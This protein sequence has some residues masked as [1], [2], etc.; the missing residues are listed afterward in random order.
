VID[1]GSRQP[2]SNLAGDAIRMRATAHSVGPAL[3]VARDKTEIAIEQSAAPLVDERGR[4]R[5]AIIVLRDI[6]GR[7]QLQEQ[8][9]EA[10]KMDAVGRLADAVAG[11]FNNVLTVINGYTDLLRAQLPPAG[12]LRRSGAP[13]PGPADR[14]SLAAGFA[15]LRRRNIF[16]RISDHGRFLSWRS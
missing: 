11:D 5:G 7:R 14:F 4:L 8:L 13:D 12:P 9:S 10:R 1:E 2:A 15:F 6:T 16:G 3:L